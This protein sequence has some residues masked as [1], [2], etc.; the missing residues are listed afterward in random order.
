M[1][2]KLKEKAYFDHINTLAD[3]GAL[4]GDGTSVPLPKGFIPGHHMEPLDEEARQALAKVPKA[5][6]N[7][8]TPMML[9]P[10]GSVEAMT[11]ALRRALAPQPGGRAA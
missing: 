3:E 6:L 5:D 2:F 7:L 11:E 4:I 10:N 1:K 9:Q 8:T